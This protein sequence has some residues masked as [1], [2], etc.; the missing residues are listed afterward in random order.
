MS[1]NSFGTSTRKSGI[2]IRLK[3][4]IF[5]NSK[6]PREFF[7]EKSHSAEKPKRRRCEAKFMKIYKSDLTG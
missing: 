7:S 2:H 1:K 3:I 4:H 5:P 6:H